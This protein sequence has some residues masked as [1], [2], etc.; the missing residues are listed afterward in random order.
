MGSLRPFPFSLLCF[1][2]V[3]D[4]LPE[5]LSRQQL[6]HFKQGEV[7]LYP[8]LSTSLKRCSL[9]RQ[10]CGKKNSCLPATADTTSPSAKEGSH[11]SAVIATKK[12]KC[13]HHFNTNR[14]YHR[15]LKS[16]RNHLQ[17]RERKEVKQLQ[18]GGD[19]CRSGRKR[20]PN[21]VIVLLLIASSL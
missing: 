20:M 12:K 4:T 11:Y 7:S 17:W 19:S 16:L 21:L 8:S 9:V 2:F 10:V 3:G 6:P 1:C 18:A 15:D 13:L 5:V 14:L